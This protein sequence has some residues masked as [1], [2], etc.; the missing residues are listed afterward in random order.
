MGDPG[1]PAAASTPTLPVILASGYDRAQVMAGAGSVQPRAFLGKP[2]S[3]QNLREALGKAL[4]SDED[5]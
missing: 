2:F 1:R 5:A 4:Q 3:L